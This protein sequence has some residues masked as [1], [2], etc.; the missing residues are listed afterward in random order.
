MLCMLLGQVDLV[1]IDGGGEVPGE[2]ANVKH[3][4]K[5][6]QITSNDKSMYLSGMTL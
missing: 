2:I 6:E 3:T 1:P 5:L 4:E